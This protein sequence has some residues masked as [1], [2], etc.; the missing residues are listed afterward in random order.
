MLSVVIWMEPP[1]PPPDPDWSGV[2][3]RPL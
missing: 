3:M 2:L 1:L